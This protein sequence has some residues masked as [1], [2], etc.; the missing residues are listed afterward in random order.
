VNSGHLRMG[1]LSGS[2]FALIRYLGEECVILLVNPTDRP[3]SA[4]VYPALLYKGED[5]ETD[6]P[7][8][9]QYTELFTGESLRVRSVLRVL[10]PPEGYCIYRKESNL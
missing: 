2:C 7:L 4:S 5:G 3:V 1:A 6:V 9:G 8:T 10:V